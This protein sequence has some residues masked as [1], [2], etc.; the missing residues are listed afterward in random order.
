MPLAPEGVVEL[1]QDSLALHWSQAEAYETQAAHFRRWGY[2]KLAETWAEYAVEERGHVAK[3]V[4][5][6][7]FYNVEPTREHDVTEWPRHDFLGVLESN[8]EGDT[9]ASGVERQGFRTATVVGDADTAKIFAK[10]LRGSEQS[11]QN[12]EAVR[13]VIGTIG[14][15]N[16]LANQA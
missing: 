16:Y 9:Q 7:E 2:P 5:R 1:M 12:I 6:L 3:L 13:E 14:L 10:L 4:D 8:Y 11:L 15:D